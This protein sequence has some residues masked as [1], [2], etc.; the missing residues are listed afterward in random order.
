[1]ADPVLQPVALSAPAATPARWSLS[2]RILF[3]FAFVYLVFYCWPYAGRSN[4]FDA[5]PSFGLGAAN[6]DDALGLTKFAE[7]PWRALCPW[8]AGHVLHLHGE[9]TK[10]HPTGSGD[11]TLDYVQVFC[12]ATIAAGVALVWSLVDRR[13]PNYRTLYPW[14]RLL[15][16]FTLAFTMLS[17][18]FA[19]VYP[20]Q[21]VPPYMTTLAENY[22]ES[23]PMGIL[24]TFM[25]ASTAYTRFGGLAE[26]TAGVL[27]LFRRTTVIGALVATAVMLN[28][29]M[30][31]FCY[32]VPVKLY[33]VH[34]ILMSL[35]LLIP[36]AAA[37][38]RFFILHKP[39]RLEGVWLPPFERRWLRI[40]AVT[41]QA[42]VI[43]SVLYNNIWGGYRNLK[44]YSA[45]FFKHAPLYG[46]WNADKFTADGSQP[47]ALPE[48]AR[49][50]QLAVQQARWLYLRNAE[51]TRIFFQTTYDEAKHTVK[52]KSGQSKQEGDF[53]YQQPDNQHLV[54]RGN[55]DGHPIV[56]EFHRFD[57]QYLLTTRGFHWISEYPFN[58]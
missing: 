53:T 48:G 9:V 8:V 34:L 52:F 51:G 23:S 14:L 18:G 16:R 36:D 30:L 32:D 3:R 5:I 28:I 4:L 44:Q 1:M 20:L 35:F 46:V 41:L 38:L 7:A 58:R 47:A 17:Y 10:Y 22:G 39:A 49:W 13:R 11:T 43:V 21:F 50:R 57:N 24:W 25:G 37:L 54:L 15:V 12:F 33:S 27:L 29:A 31:N 19:K 6:E 42:L 2:A 40:A 55:L 56:A 45:T 26:V